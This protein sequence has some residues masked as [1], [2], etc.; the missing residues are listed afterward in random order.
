MAGKAGRMYGGS[1]PR[2]KEKNSTHQP[3]HNKGK[4]SSRKRNAATACARLNRNLVK[5]NNNKD[6]GK[7]PTMSTGT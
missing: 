3:A 4:P 2:D 1:L 5:G 7:Q 6:H